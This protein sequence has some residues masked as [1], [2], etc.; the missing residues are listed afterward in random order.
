MKLRFNGTVNINGHTFS[1]KNISIENGPVI[2]D[3]RIENIAL[4]HHIVVNVNGDVEKIETASGDVNVS[5]NAS[6]IST[7]S[8]NIQ[9]R[10][11]QG[12]VKSI[13]GDIT[14]GVIHG[15][16]NTVSGDIFRR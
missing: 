4:D 6:S 15:N 8:G 12:S 9:C 1:G 10:D 13:S 14:C 3:G 16:V 5:G 11:V 7:T 2:I